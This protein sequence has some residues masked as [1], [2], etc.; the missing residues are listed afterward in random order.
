MLGLRGLGR[1]LDDDA[2]PRFQARVHALLAPVVAELGE[3]VAGEDDL[4]GKLRGLL[5]GAFAVQGADED[6]RARARAW[7]DQAEASPGSVDAELV[8][9]AT[10]IVAA[11]GDEPMYERL[12]GRLPRRR[13]TRRS[14][15]ATS[16][17]SA[18]STPRR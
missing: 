13:P 16:T 2:Y 6:M 17:R 7:Y 1:L 10:S 12:L 15:C 3:P 4:R 5:A 8:A 18:S 14:S 11:T 9:A